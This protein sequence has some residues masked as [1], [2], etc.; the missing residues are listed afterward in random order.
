DGN[1]ITSR[2]AGTA[3]PF[4]LRLIEVLSGAEAAKAVSDGIVYNVTV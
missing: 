4:G 1:V 3:I 2:G